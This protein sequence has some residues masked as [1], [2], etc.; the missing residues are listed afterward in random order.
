MFNN[1]LKT[2]VPNSLKTRSAIRQTTLFDIHLFFGTD[3][4]A[5]KSHLLTV[6]YQM[7]T[8]SAQNPLFAIAVHR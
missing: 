2:V 7:V 3:S 6:L 1:P 8:I 4:A 5:G